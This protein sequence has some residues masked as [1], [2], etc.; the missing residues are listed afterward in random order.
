MLLYSAIHL[1][2][3]CA[4]MQQAAPPRQANPLYEKRP[5]QFG[6]PPAGLLCLH[7]KPALVG[8]CVEALGG[9]QAAWLACEPFCLDIVVPSASMARLLVKVACLTTGVGGVPP[10]RK[11]MHR[12]VK[13]PKYVRIQR[14]RRV[15]NQRLK[16]PPA[17]NRFT[18]ALD[19]NTA[20]TL[21]SI[22]LKYRPEDRAAKKVCL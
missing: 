6:A 13:W 16:V 11:D 22:L 14:Q 17:L 20:Q 3:L 21:F 19:R 7:S 4:Q 10:P 18:K 2:A 9:H 8:F 5:K 15:L 12:F 1:E